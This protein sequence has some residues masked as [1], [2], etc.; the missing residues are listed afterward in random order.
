[1]GGERLLYNENNCPTSLFQLPIAENVNDLTLEFDE[2]RKPS[3]LLVDMALFGR[4]KLYLKLRKGA[5]KL[6]L[7]C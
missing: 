1:M 5:G 2:K 7:L 6:L 3:A 4:M